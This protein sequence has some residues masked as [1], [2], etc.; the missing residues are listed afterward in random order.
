M[1]PRRCV[2]ERLPAMCGSDTL[3]T[4]VS[5]TSMKVANITAIAMIQ[6]LTCR[7]SGMTDF[8]TSLDFLTGIDSRRDRHAGPQQVLGILP[9]FEHDLDRHALHDLHVVAGGVFW[10]QQAEARPGRRGDAVDLALEFASAVRVDFDRGRAVPDACPSA[11][12]P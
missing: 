8:L 3:T 1:S 2:A 9:R 11:A 6:G 4:V 12:S 5:S 7:C 10:R